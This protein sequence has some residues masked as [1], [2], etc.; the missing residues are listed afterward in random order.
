MFHAPLERR[1][2]DLSFG[3]WQKNPNAFMDGVT[4][5]FSLHIEPPSYFQVSVW[6]L[7]TIHV[8]HPSFNIVNL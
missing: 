3:I 6:Q 1:G 5:G 2:F 8:L 4:N 7:L